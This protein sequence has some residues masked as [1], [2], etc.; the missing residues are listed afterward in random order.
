[1]FVGLSVQTRRNACRA[2]LSS[3][4]PLTKVCN[5]SSIG[6]YR[7][8]RYFTRLTLSE[9]VDPMKGVKSKVEPK[10]EDGRLSVKRKASD[11]AL[12]F[13]AREFTYREDLRYV[14]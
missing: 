7:S 2:G 5:F 14:L 11:R 1:M 8:P 12:L 6:V 4:D 3:Y 10:N 13:S 9:P